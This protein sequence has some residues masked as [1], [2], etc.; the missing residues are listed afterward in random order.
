MQERLS[1]GA[2]SRYRIGYKDLRLITPETANGFGLSAEA[3][4]FVSPYVSGN[5]KCFDCGSSYA[6]AV[7]QSGRVT[8]SHGMHKYHGGIY[9]HSQ[10]KRVLYHMPWRAGIIALG[11]VGNGRA[12]KVFADSIRATVSVDG[13]DE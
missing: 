8:E 12:E 4:V 10:Y 3:P 9:F 2:V 6:P 5:E 7:Y 1:G 13:K 11:E